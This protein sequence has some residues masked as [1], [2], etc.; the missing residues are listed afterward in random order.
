MMDQMMG[1][2]ALFSVAMFSL[3]SFL[4]AY[5]V[6]RKR[7]EKLDEPD[8][9]LGIKAVL[10]HFQFVNIYCVLLG[11][12]LIF[13]ALFE[14]I[15]G[16]SAD[17][18]K[19]GLGTL[20]GA[21]ALFAAFETFLRLWT[22]QAQYGDP[23]KVFFGMTLVVVGLTGIAAFLLFWIGLFDKWKGM[24]FN[25]PFG[26]WLIFLP[27]TAAGLLYFRQ[28]YFPPAP[29]AA[30]GGF[31]GGGA[32]GGPGVEQPGYQQPQQ[33]QQPVQPG[34]EQPAQPQQP[35]YEQPGYQQPG[36]Q[37]PGYQQPGYEQPGYQQPG[38]EQPGYQQPQ[39]PGQPQ[40]PGPGLP[41]PSGG[42]YGGGFGQ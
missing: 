5:L 17:L 7:A 39:Q 34:Y 36:Y 20:F 10:N 8:E 18:W 19:T 22:N 2:A 9:Q 16:H 29:G 21:A 33:P 41:P 15:G 23:R 25:L 32:G 12:A 28:L 27:A 14:K 37:Q 1:T 24:S 3:L 13:T 11:L 30:A 6:L 42:G 35:G 40:P 4:A 26:V 31:P 38:Y